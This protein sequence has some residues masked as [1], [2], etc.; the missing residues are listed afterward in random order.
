MLRA[1]VL[2]VQQVLNLRCT[3][4]KLPK[5]CHQT[6][7]LQTFS[8]CKAVTKTT[9]VTTTNKKLGN[10]ASSEK[11]PTDESGSGSS[12]LK[13]QSSNDSEDQRNSKT[14]TVQTNS[15]D[16]KDASDSSIVP[17]GVCGKKK[18]AADEAWE[19]SDDEPK[20]KVAKKKSFF[21][22]KKSDEPKTKSGKKR[23]A[24]DIAWE[25]SDDDDD[26]DQA[27][28]ATR[29]RILTWNIDMDTDYQMIRT[30]A[31]ISEIRSA[32]PDVVM[33]QEVTD[34]GDSSVLA[35]LQRAL[36]TPPTE[37]EDEDEVPTYNLYTPHRTDMYFCL[38][39]ARRGVFSADMESS[40]R[41]FPNSAMGRGIISLSGK[42]VDDGPKIQA[43][44]AHLESLKMGTE[45]RKQQFAS[46]IEKL[47]ESAGNG[48]TA[49]FGGDTNLRENE[50]LASEVAKT[51]AEE[52]KRGKVS[53]SAALKKAKKLP[54]IGDAWV[55]AGANDKEKFTWDT[56]RNDNLQIDSQFKPRTRYDR[57]FLFGPGT[58]FPQVVSYRLL[59]TKRLES[60]GVFISDHFGVL[61][62]VDV[63]NSGK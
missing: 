48:V 57:I 32:R 16:S 42:L 4:T 25:M 37:E 62:D 53:K 5:T 23:S 26:D 15:T 18:N 51:I 45:A 13:V 36:C 35:A 55:M 46:V 39:L 22:S 52:A 60:C 33:L 41:A 1:F 50:V 30:R 8:M 20:T 49:F 3:V 61:V 6:P 17:K 31:L 27:G 58:A 40:A 34:N 63:F 21:V 43:I 54:K 47:R 29:L 2:P 9:S 28:E 10:T 11:K 14:I 44:T 12:K 56:L 59:G 24:A 19:I 38:L 7:R